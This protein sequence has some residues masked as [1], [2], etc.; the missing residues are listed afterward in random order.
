LAT[1]K[2]APAFEYGSV[3]LLRKTGDF[4]DDVRLFEGEP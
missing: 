2:A 4:V 1:G 3:E